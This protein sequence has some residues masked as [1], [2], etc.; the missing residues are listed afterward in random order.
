M[1]EKHGKSL[2]FWFVL[3]IW[4][5]Q[6][7]SA[8]R[9]H[10]CFLSRV[11][12]WSDVL[13]SPSKIFVDRNNS[14][15]AYERSPR[16]VEAVQT[17]N[18]R[19][20]T[21]SFRLQTGGYKQNTRDDWLRK[22][23]YSDISCFSLSVSLEVLFSVTKDRVCQVVYWEYYFRLFMCVWNNDFLKDFKLIIF[24]DHFS[25]FSLDVNYNID[26]E[27]LIKENLKFFG[28]TILF[29]KRFYLLYRVRQKYEYT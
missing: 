2:R 17:C 7:Q 20:Q 8:Y 25:S 13:C 22:V 6:F 10:M 16:T 28:N 4:E 27:Q 14:Y 29:E 3:A 21:P 15:N 5:N 9:I 26:S 23:S 11:I 18:S 19:R 1:W 24:I 12:N